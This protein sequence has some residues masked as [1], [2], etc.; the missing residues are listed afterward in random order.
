MCIKP[1]P[2]DILVR[3]LCLFETVLQ[4]TECRCGVSTA[5][6]A[7]LIYVY[8]SRTQCYKTATKKLHEYNISL[9]RQLCSMNAFAIS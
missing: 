7:T 2:P 9:D 4:L 3:L 6:G 8:V 5:R 1:L